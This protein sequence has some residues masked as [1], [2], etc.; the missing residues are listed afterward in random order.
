MSAVIAAVIPQRQ[1][2]QSMFNVR[3]HGES[4]RLTKSL[5]HQLRRSADK[6]ADL[7]PGLSLGSI[8]HTQSK[9]SSATSANLTFFFCNSRRAYRPFGSFNAEFVIRSLRC[10][11]LRR[12][13]GIRLLY[14]LQVAGCKPDLQAHWLRTRNVSTETLSKGK[15]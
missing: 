5:T 4:A 13:D 1:G 3:I 7:L 12:N 11:V 2:H 6:L 15:Q 8:A 14:L 10:P 9:P